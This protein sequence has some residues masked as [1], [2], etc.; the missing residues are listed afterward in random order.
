MAAAVSC[1]LA[2]RGIRG[3]LYACEFATMNSNY[4]VFEVIFTT[5]KIIL[6][7]LVTLSI[8]Y[9]L[10]NYFVILQLIFLQGLN[11]NISPRVGIPL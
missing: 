2:P 5:T 9:E 8:L 3:E 7:F 10:L 6:L 1:I 4:L 11:A